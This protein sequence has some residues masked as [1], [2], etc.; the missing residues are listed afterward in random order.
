[1]V[2]GRSAN[3]EDQQLA[4]SLLKKLSETHHLDEPA[5]WKQYCLVLLNTNEFLYL[6]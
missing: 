1:M 6:D 5:Q 3:P 4:E 2:Y